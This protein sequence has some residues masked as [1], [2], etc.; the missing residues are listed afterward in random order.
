MLK[1]LIGA[2]HVREYLSGTNRWIISGTDRVSVYLSSQ[3]SHCTV[4]GV[5]MSG[6]VRL[7]LATLLPLLMLT[8]LIVLPTSVDATSWDEQE[9][10][11]IS[12]PGTVASSP[13]LVAD[14]QM[15]V[16]VAWSEGQ[17]DIM[18]RSM[19]H[20][21]WG[22]AEKVSI[23]STISSID[24]SMAIDGEGNVHL[25]WVEWSYDQGTREIVQRSMIDGEWG[26]INVLSHD[27]NDFSGLPSIAASEDG[28]V[29][30]VWADGNNPN[31]K[32]L[33]RSGTGNSWEPIEEVRSDGNGHPSWPIVAAGPGR[34]VHVIWYDTMEFQ[35]AEEG[36]ADIFHRSK[37]DS[38]WGHTELVSSGS[39]KYSMT[40]DVGVDAEGVVH[41]TW[42]DETDFPGSES[43][44]DIY[45][46]AKADGGWQ[47]VELVSAGSVNYSE[48]A[49]LAI[50]PEGDLHIVWRESYGK[51]LSDIMHS[52]LSDEGWG[53]YTT[54]STET[55]M[56]AD[57]TI[58]SDGLVHVHVVWMDY[59]DHDELGDGSFAYHKKLWASDKALVEGVILDAD[60]DPVQG[61]E[62]WVSNPGL[63]A[64]TDEKGRYAFAIDEGE[65]VIEAIKDGVTMQTMSITA[66]GGESLVVEP[67]SPETD[68]SPSYLIYI[69]AA[70]LG[71][72]AIILMVMR[73]R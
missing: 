34:G 5:N 69:I 14:S 4:G 33:Y 26:Q 48:H 27:K 70:A 52:S 16:H 20:G 24:P 53:T 49:S 43:G 7:V 12:G 46:R 51:D 44:S 29:H 59:G 30:V 31:T 2:S 68:D 72:V 62:I 17:D 42:N 32:I 10:H 67:S 1:M 21:E 9:R 64:V 25:A 15:N 66:S 61:V 28:R 60:G 11:M 19:S 56:S 40:G 55:D 8:S 73:S 47:D 71:L 50:T 58:T 57:P 35:G 39:D 63:A 22:D 3:T 13:L 65:Y 23:S 38:T 45:H 18:F 36:T 6:S 37:S 54:V 41:V